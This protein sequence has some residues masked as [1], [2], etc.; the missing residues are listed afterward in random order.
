MC[1]LWL[2]LIGLQFQFPC[3][4]GKLG[5]ACLRAALGAAVD[6]RFRGNDNML[7]FSLHEE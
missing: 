3:V 1:L 4:E 6:S 2:G 5:R 7:G